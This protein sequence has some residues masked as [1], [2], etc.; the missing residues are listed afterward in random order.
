MSWQY[1]PPE[2]GVARFPAPKKCCRH[3]FLER[4]CFEDGS[5]QLCQKR[6][7]EARAG[8]VCSQNLA[9]G[10][11]KIIRIILLCNAE[12]RKKVN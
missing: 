10:K 1:Q 9:S 2:Q 3:H 4:H 7:L 12:E 8:F 5:T 6:A 11:E